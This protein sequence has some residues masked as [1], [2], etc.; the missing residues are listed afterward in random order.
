M[1][2]ALV[3]TL[4]TALVALNSYVTVRVL[5]SVFFGS[6]QKVAQIAL[7]WFL[8]LFGALLVLRVMTDEPVV[9]NEHFEQIEQTDRIGI[10]GEPT[11]W[12]GHHDPLP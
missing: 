7:I 12:S 10:N 8:P 3:I 5:R 2:T 9:H 1:I 6:G 4:T 11:P